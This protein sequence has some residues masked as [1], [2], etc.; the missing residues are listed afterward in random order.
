M[1]NPAKTW[2]DVDLDRLLNSDVNP[3]D[4][5]VCYVLCRML[6]SQMLHEG[7]V[8]DYYEARDAIAEEFHQ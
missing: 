1:V 2:Y 5:D 4:E 6:L 3:S 7:P 8:K